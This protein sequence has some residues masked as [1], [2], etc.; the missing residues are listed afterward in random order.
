MPEILS[1]ARYTDAPTHCGVCGEPIH[2]G[3]RFIVLDLAIP[4]TP[5]YPTG[6]RAKLALHDTLACRAPVGKWMAASGRDLAD[7]S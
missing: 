5:D 6:S 7:R 4:P 1:G 3:E 2:Q